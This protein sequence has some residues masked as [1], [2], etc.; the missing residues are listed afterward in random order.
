MSV[1]AETLAQRWLAAL[2]HERRASPH[3]L[4]AYGRVAR[5]FVFFLGQH[6][7]E[8]VTAETLAQADL[9][10]F[11]AFLARRRTE[12]AGPS[13]VAHA[14]SSL[15][16]WYRWLARAEGLKNPAIVALQSPKANKPLPRPLAPVDAAGI[17]EAA[18]RPDAEPWIAARDTAV[19]LLLYGCG[20]RISEALGLKRSSAPMQEAI[21]VLGK[22]NKERRVPI[23]PIVA[24]AVEDY[25]AVCPYPLPLEGP[26]FIGARGGPLNPRIVQLAM[27]RARV[28]LGLPDSATPHA[29]RHSFATHLLARG[30]DLRAIQELL[31]HASLS[32]TQVYTEV[33]AA[34]ILDIYRHAHPRA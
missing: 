19:L 5:Q 26:L 21:T 27:Q 9:T 10:D 20:L 22:R 4:T 1:D 17:A 16:A 32:S 8:Q 6:T 11:R 31:G 29:L 33:D 34:R 2:A 23:L 13:T 7:G 18:E 15:K 30:A 25:L 3:T 14:A 28:S 24:E 12:G